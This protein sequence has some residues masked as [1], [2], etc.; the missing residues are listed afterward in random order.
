MS[1]IGNC[2]E[3]KYSD[4]SVLMQP[5]QVQTRISSFMS[6]VFPTCEQL[7]CYLTYASFTLKSLL[8]PPQQTSD[9]P[10]SVLFN[11]LLNCFIL[12]K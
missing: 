12:I 2:K 11:F 10:L 1:S 6:T 4:Y 9:Q 5:E 3:K 8:Q 7:S